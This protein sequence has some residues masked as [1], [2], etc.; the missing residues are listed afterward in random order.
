MCGSAGEKGK[1]GGVFYPS[2]YRRYLGDRYRG[3]E[4]S[5]ERSSY[6]RRISEAWETGGKE[7]DKDRI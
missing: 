1:T 2:L 5:A 6:G 4:G 7:K 3:E